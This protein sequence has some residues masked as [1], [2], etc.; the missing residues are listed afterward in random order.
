MIDLGSVHGLSTRFACH[1]TG[2]S[3]Q[4]EHVL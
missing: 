2:A 4:A 3:E 1:M